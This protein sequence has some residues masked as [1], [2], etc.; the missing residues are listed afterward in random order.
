MFFFMCCPSGTYV[1]FI[2]NKGNRIGNRNWNEKQTK[3][4]FS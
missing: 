2:L 4:N 1:L 3:H